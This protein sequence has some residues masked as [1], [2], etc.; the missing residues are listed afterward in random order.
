MGSFPGLC[1]SDDSTSNGKASN[2][3]SCTAVAG[4]HRHS[5]GAVESHPRSRSDATPEVDRTVRSTP[6]EAMPARHEVCFVVHAQR[7]TG[8][9]FRDQELVG[10]KPVTLTF[11]DER[12]PAAM[13]AAAGGGSAFSDASNGLSATDGDSTANWT[14]HFAKSTSVEEMQ[15]RVPAPANLVSPVEGQSHTKLTAYY[16]SIIARPQPDF[17]KDLDFQSG[18]TPN[19]LAVSPRLP[20]LPSHES[21][22]S[23]STTGSLSGSTDAVTAAQGYQPSPV[24]E[25]FRLGMFEE[26][27]LQ[28]QN[29]SCSPSRS[30]DTASDPENGYSAAQSSHA[31]GSAPASGELMDC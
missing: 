24:M 1:Q 26:R 5:E 30:R 3:D 9:W 23:C 2:H 31:P 11:D 29:C 25:V 13:S 8:D 17:A 10:Q 12:T 6:D 27:P 20:S 7:A 15:V 19:P 14:L 18:R 4:G 22:R 16:L 28:R 21:L